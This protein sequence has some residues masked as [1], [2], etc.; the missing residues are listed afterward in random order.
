MEMAIFPMSC[1]LRGFYAC[2]VLNVRLGKNP[3]AVLLIEKL[4]ISKRRYFANDQNLGF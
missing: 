2:D 4:F 1:V 3:C